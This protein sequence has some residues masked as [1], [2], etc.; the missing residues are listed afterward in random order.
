MYIKSPEQFL[1]NLLLYNFSLLRL[2][3][4]SMQRHVSKLNEFYAAILSMEVL[5]TNSEISWKVM[6]LS[7]N[8]WNSFQKWPSISEK[9]LNLER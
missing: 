5:S 8:A 7:N 6:T 1:Q 4:A 9:D 3:R 2:Q